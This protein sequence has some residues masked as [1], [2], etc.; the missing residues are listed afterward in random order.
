MGDEEFQLGSGAWSQ[1]SRSS[2]CSSPS[3]TSTYA[4][5]TTQVADVMKS[6]ALLLNTNDSSNSV[7]ANLFQDSHKQPLHQD[8]PNLHLMGLGLSSQ[9]MDWNQ[10][11]RRGIEKSDENS[12]FRS[13]LQ[14][15]HDQLSSNTTNFQQ[16]EQQW[17]PRSQKMMMYSSSSAATDSEGVFSS[18]NP[19]QLLSSTHHHH[20]LNPNTIDHLDSSLSMQYQNNPST[21]SMLPGLLGYEINHQ[22]Q[23]QQQQ[24]QSTPFDNRSPM[25]NFNS[26]PTSYGMNSSSSSDH[27]H[28]QLIMQ[29]NP[30]PPNNK[31][32]NQLHLSNNAPF[33]NASTAA[34]IIN[35]DVRSNFFPSLQMQS[36]SSTFDEKPKKSS[37]SETSNKRPRNE[38]PSP[39]PAKAR[40]EKMGDRITALQQLVSP[41]GKT[42]TASVLSEAIDYIKFLHDQVSVLSTGYMKTGAPIQQQQQQKCDKSKDSEGQKQDLRSRGLCLVPVSS[43]FPVNHETTVDFWNPTFGGTFR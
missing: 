26:Y 11:F 6:P 16:A 1:R 10:H 19:S 40:K 12:S 8:N 22:P 17:P 33:W 37:S 20:H 32:Q 35:H 39:V 41:F 18:L 25:T 14:E 13:M 27:D 9:P 42:D 21:T 30:W 5:Q 7:S 31:P 23:Q 28:H 3:S 2:R 4:W 43:T 34:P 36:A 15:D 38:T 24:Q 29:P